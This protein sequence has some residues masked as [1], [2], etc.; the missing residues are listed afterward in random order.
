M[1]AL[2]TINRREAHLRLTTIAVFLG[3]VLN[4]AVEADPESADGGKD[5]TEE[6]R[7]LVMQGLEFAKKDD[8]ALM[9]FA[10]DFAIPDASA[11][12]RTIFGE[13]VGA[14]IAEQY[15]NEA[16]EVPQK[17][18]ERFR[19]LAKGK[20]SLTVEVK[21]I[22]DPEIADRAN[23]FILQAMR[24]GISIYKV[25][26]YTDDG[27]YLY[28]TLVFAGEKFRQ[29]E[30]L[31]EAI[32]FPDRCSLFLFQ[33]GIY[34]SLFEAKFSR[35]AIDLTEIIREDML[36]DHKYLRCPCHPSIEPGFDYFYPF[37]EAATDASAIV[38]WDKSAHSDGK[39]SVLLYNGNVESLTDADFHRRLSAQRKASIPGLKKAIATNDSWTVSDREKAPPRQE[40]LKAMQHLLGECEA[41]R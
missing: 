41:E 30:C 17:V 29:I 2:L 7:A 4:S 13:E 25:D 37:G 1:S 35:C 14:R 19:F 26:A 15:A 31:P 32:N 36:T 12:L 10:N 27:W 8:A 22:H 34:L 6:V 20:K 23:K 40:R 3:A 9:K 18:A 33:D 11:W 5:R 21:R 16:K 38:A 39:R 28:L 24:S